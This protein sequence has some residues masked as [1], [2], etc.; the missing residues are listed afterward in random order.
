MLSTYCGSFSQR[1]F[2]KHIAECG[3]CWKDAQGRSDLDFD[4]SN[5]LNPDQ[6]TESDR[7]LAAMIES[8]KNLKP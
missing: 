2:R 7:L 1:Q 3:V 5:V 8:R 6:Q 4:P